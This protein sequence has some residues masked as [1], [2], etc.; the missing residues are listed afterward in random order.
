MIPDGNRV[1]NSVRRNVF[2][3]GHRNMQGIDFAADG[4][5]Y[6]A[7]QGPKTDAAVN[8]LRRGN[9]YDWPHVARFPNDKTY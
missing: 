2:T 3:W 7:K 5:L 1:L 6:A 8:I 4:T 9:N